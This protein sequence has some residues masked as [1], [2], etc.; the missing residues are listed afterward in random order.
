MPMRG[1]MLGGVSLALVAA[2][3]GVFLVAPLVIAVWA[4]LDARALT[5]VFANPVYRSG[6]VNALTIA[7]VTTVIALALTV[8]LAWFGARHRFR[9]KG[10]AEALLLAPL[11]L[12]PFVGALGVYQILGQYGVLNT[13][14]ESLGL[15]A[16][17][18]GPDWLGDHRFAVVCA[19][20]ALGL[21]PV[22]YLLLNAA[23]AKIDPSLLEA[24]RGLGASRFTTFRRVVLPLV[25]PGL[26]GGAV[27]VFV[28]SFTELGTPLML[29]YDR[30]TPVQV[31]AAMADIGSNRLPYALVVVMLAIAMALYALSR[32]LFARRYDALAAKG[33]GAGG[34]DSAAKRL[35]GWRAAAAWLP[36]LALCL[37]AML[38]HLAVLL[39]GMSRDWYHTVLPH[40]FSLIH[41]NEALSNENVVPGIVNSVTY[42]TAA[43]VLG[44]IV[45]T[46]IAWTCVRWRPAGWQAFDIAA[47]VPLAVPGIIFA[48]GYIG[49]AYASPLL[50]SWLD[51]FRNPTA[52]LIIAYAI[53]RLPHV[54][55]AASAGLSQA[56]E[57][58]EEAAASLGA[59]R[60]TRLR[61]ITLPLIAGS[62]AAGA[63][64]TFSFSM[65]EVSDSLILAQKREF[66]PIT[67]V[68]YDLVN[69]LGS[70]PAIACAFAA[71][72]MLFLTATLAAAAVFLGRNPSSLFRD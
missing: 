28:W 1:S 29:G 20:E 32:L 16:V 68:I 57:V 22:L 36:Y 72:A 43:T 45:G 63:L 11:I 58:F 24:S 17:G 7:S 4:G 19:V 26:F 65:L 10:L 5:E 55:R 15:Y 14:L 53:R 42:A 38:P 3:L 9:G 41:V 62:L 2:F 52:L 44:M 35:S 67:R 23:F 33:A 25:R 13:L 6:I 61:R 48:F 40:G 60:W 69:V 27:I 37:L 66:W 59:N 71:W 18:R 51:P 46:F 31:F 47:M 70:G 50:R 21:Y 64:M 49:L 12:P 30:V 8:P 39:T 34:M 56:P 54:V